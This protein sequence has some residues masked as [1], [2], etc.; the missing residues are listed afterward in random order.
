MRG[1]QVSEDTPWRT[2]TRP[3][4]ARTADCPYSSDAATPSG[5]VLVDQGG[6][7]WLV[8]RRES[9]GFGCRPECVRCSHLWDGCASCASTWLVGSQ[10][11]RKSRRPRVGEP[12][13]V[14]GCEPGV[15]CD[16]A[17]AACSYTY[18]SRPEGLGYVNTYCSQSVFTRRKPLRAS[19]TVW[20]R[21]SD[22]NATLTIAPT[23]V[24]KGATCI[25]D[26]GPNRICEHCSVCS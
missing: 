21:P 6:G 11:L 10:W 3:L 23:R 20:P 14:G 22:R 25:S 1:R 26:R 7:L 12:T 8:R 2:T 24:V 9:G 15:Q 16:K 4:S 5:L 17:G 18:P 19:W 13:A